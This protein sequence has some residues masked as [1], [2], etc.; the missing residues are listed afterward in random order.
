[1]P[2]NCPAGALH[3]APQAFADRSS[4]A[5]PAGRRGPAPA[6]TSAGA[7]RLR[8]LLLLCLLLCACVDTREPVVRIGINP[9]PGYAFA[10]L[11]R[12]LGY[13]AAAGVNVRLYEFSSLADSRRAFE[14][15]QLDGFFGT[16]VEVLLA[17]ARTGRDLRIALVADVSV[18]GDVI[19][20]APPVHTLA[21]LRGKRVGLEQDSVNLFVLARALAE[22]GLTLADVERVELPQNRLNEALVAG[23]IAGA[24]SYPPYSDEARGAG[25]ASVVFDS[26]GLADGVI[27]LLVL[28]HGRAHVDDAVAHAISAAY[29]RAFAYTRTAP[30]A[31]HERLAAYL[32]MAAPELAHFLARDLRIP[33]AERQ[34]QLLQREGSVHR[35]LS[36]VAA[37]L[38]TAH[39]EH[40]APTTAMIAALLPRT[41]A[42]PAR[43]SAP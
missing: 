41:T 10:F 24:V 30:A 34:P 33:G 7:G 37:L 16:P 5:H 6:R 22:A 31:A 2:L 36:D 29:W 40:T 14:R 43:R 25:G 19:L 35:Q 12:D 11:A 27:D 23:S 26:A 13:F 32:G 4:I 9:W 3:D 38:R 42:R 21:E 1:M 17:Q 15:G 28:D 20:A 18:G 8:A 39:P